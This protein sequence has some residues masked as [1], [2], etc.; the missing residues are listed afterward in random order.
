MVSV[1]SSRGVH[2]SVRTIELRPGVPIGGHMLGC[3]GKSRR[4]ELKIVLED[5]T[6]GEGDAL[7]VLRCLPAGLIGGFD[8][9]TVGGFLGC[10]AMGSR[11]LVK[12]RGGLGVFCRGYE[13][14][15]LHVSCSARGTKRRSGISESCSSSLSSRVRSM[16]PL[17]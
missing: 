8:R 2:S 4:R 5:K 6:A 15:V 16:T 11:P 10:V 1:E 12:V 17:S 13:V 3:V 9:C 14:V 7:M